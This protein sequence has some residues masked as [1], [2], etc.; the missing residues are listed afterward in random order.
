MHLYRS[1]IADFKNGPIT[2]TYWVM[3]EFLADTVL[4][5]FI[6]LDP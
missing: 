5:A 6:R 1:A 4:L 3:S 2:L